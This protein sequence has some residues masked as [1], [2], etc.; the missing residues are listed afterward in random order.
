MSN[1]AVIVFTDGKK[2]YTDNNIAIYLH[3]NGGLPKV[4][5]MLNA[6][7]VLIKDRLGDEAYCIARFIQMVG[8]YMSP[9]LTSLGVGTAGSLDCDNGDNGTY[10]VDFNTL[11]ILARKYA[12][13]EG[14]KKSETE[15]TFAKIIAA[16]TC[17]VEED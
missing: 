11:K 16:N 17:M 7:K 3:W 2:A 15:A 12:C 10:V 14:L 9:G 6:G 13:G 4:Q 8:N 1:S 5:G